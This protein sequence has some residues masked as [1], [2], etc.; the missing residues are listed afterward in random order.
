MR[1]IAESEFLEWAEGVGLCVSPDYPDSVVLI[2]SKDKGELSRFWVI[3]HEPEKRPHFI[4]L[5]LK[6]LG[7]WQFCS[8]WRSMGSWHDSSSISKDRVNDLVEFRILSGLGLPLGTADIVQFDIEELDFLITLIFSTTIFGWS[9]G[10]DIYVVP[11]HGRQF[12]KV[13]HHNV[14]HVDFRDNAD[15]QKW[16]RRMLD[17]GYPLP[18]EVPDSTFIRPDWMK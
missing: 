6:L 9:V 7:P 2:Y 16:K 12:I 13:S 15:V 17:E 10:E 3:P 5:L 1:S 11:N 4:K 18:T 14:I 8:V